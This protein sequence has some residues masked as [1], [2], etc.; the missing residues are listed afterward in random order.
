MRG[1][2][3]AGPRGSKEEDLA[4]YFWGEFAYWRQRCLVGPQREMQFAVVR[5]ELLELELQAP[6][7]IV[8]GSDGV[9]NFIDRVLDNNLF[10]GRWYEGRM[11]KRRR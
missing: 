1:P 3:D 6:D 11:S 7:L 5:F 9:L 2:S 4:Q 8:N 10:V